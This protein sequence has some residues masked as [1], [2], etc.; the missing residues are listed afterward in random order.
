MK[1]RTR[2][3]VLALSA[4]TFAAACAGAKAKD[5]YAGMPVL[6]EQIATA[7]PGLQPGIAGL[8]YEIL[9]PGTGEVAAGADRV[10]VLYELKLPDGTVVDSTAWR[11]DQPL[12]LS[13]KPNS[14]MI[15]GF[16]IAVSA[17]RLGEKR[18]VAIPPELGYGARGVPGVIPEWSWLV[19]EIKV[20]AIQ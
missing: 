20:I 19:F 7:Y 16:R 5:P 10:D 2:I 8:Y 13:T 17:M 6:P 1:V 12:S 18:R 14:G 3:A 9:E 4:L 15:E 11:G